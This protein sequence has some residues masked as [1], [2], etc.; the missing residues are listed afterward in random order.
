MIRDMNRRVCV[1]SIDTMVCQVG[2]MVGGENDSK[3]IGV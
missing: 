1:V 3:F 2:A